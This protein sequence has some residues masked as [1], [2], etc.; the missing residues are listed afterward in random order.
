MIY[1]IAK[2][3]ASAE[4]YALE[5]AL[6]SS[7]WRYVCE[8]NQLRGVTQGEIHLVDDYSRGS[9]WDDLMFEVHPIEHFRSNVKVLRVRT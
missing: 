5:R 9:P 6:P 4:M 7:Q 8:R 2:S 1:L 3:F